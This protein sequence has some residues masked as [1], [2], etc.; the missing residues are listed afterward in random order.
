MRFSKSFTVDRHILSYVAR[1]ARSRSRSERI[2]ELLRQAIIQEQYQ[3]LELEAAEFFARRPA[4][5]RKETKGFQSA[6][7]RAISRD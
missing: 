5:S 4:G 3:K 2:N 7:K 6:T 1:T